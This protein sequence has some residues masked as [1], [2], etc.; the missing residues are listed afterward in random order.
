MSWWLI[1]PALLGLLFQLVVIGTNNVASPV[2]PFYSLFIVLWGVLML[3]FW[4]RKESY[5]ALK[6]GMTDFERKETYRAEF[7]WDEKINLTG[8]EIL[9]FAPEKRTRLVFESFSIIGSLCLAVVGTTAS[10]Y[11]I[12]YVLYGTAVEVGASYIASILNTIQI[13]VFNAIY[14]SMSEYLTDRE[15]HR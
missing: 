15:N 10:I 4:K 8:E 12:R 13:M 14:A 7:E 6:F 11:L 9:Y 3:E 5:T 1:F 2:I